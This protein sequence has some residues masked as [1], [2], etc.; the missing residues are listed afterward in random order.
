MNKTGTVVD[1]LLLNVAV[2]HFSKCTAAD[3]N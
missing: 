2:L 1:W 3:I